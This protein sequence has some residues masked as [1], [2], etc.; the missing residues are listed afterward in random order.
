MFRSFAVLGLA[1]SL[2]ACAASGVP[3]PDQSISEEQLLSG[4]AIFSVPA[5]TAGIADPAIL[6]VDDDMRAFV[7]EQVGNARSDRQRMQRLL[8]GMVETGLM[9][10]DY[11]DVQTKTARATFHDR[12]GNCISFT[13]LFVA[14]GREA[15]LDVSFQIVEIPPVWYADSGFVVLNNHVNALVE[16]TFA[17]RVVVDFNI[18]D[19]KGNYDTRTVSDDYALALY[20]NNVAMDELRKGNHLE[21]FRLLKKAIET[22]ATIAGQWANLGVLYLRKG[23]TDYAMSA[24]ARALTLDPDNHSALTNLATLHHKMGNREQAEHYTRKIRHYQKRNPYY[25]YSLALAAY[26]NGKLARARESLRRAIRLK[27]NEHQFFQLQGLIH[28]GQGDLDA[29]LESFDRARDVAG[30][31]DVRRKYDDKI[32]ALNRRAN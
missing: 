10:L 8:T 2:V 13:N 27:D 4:A 26:D 25:H 1:A 19:L 5:D 7:R 28:A 9:S 31:G 29:A 11:D 22:D 20:F 16:P 6:E 24:Y 12:I 30:F 23:V 18:T 21:S 32:A 3:G 15:G 14:L 17:S